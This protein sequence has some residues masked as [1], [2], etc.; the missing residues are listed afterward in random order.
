MINT[1]SVYDYTE[2]YNCC[3][4]NTNIVS[5][6]NYLVCDLSASNIPIQ[7]PKTGLKYYPSFGILVILVVLSALFPWKNQ[8][9]SQTFHF[10]LI[11]TKEDGYVKPHGKTK[12]HTPIINDRGAWN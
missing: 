11:Y 4:L 10:V 3:I 8:L 2:A 12:N 9:S 7:R 5:I 6:L 1:I